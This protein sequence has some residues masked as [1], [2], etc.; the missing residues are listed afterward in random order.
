MPAKYDRIPI[1]I[2]ILLWV[3]YLVISLTTPTT[4]NQAFQLS[5]LQRYIL[6]FTISVPL[7]AIWLSGIISGHQLHNYAEHLE[8]QD[9][10][11]TF[12]RL[13]RGIYFLVLGS[14]LTTILGSVRSR[15][16]SDFSVQMTL[17]VINNY[18]YVFMPL[19][20]LSLILQSAI[21][22]AKSNRAS[23]LTFFR[24]AAAALIPILATVG[25]VWL[26]STNPS[27]QIST[28]A[29][30]SPSY[31]LPDYLIYSTIVIPSF[32]TWLIGSLAISYLRL[33]RRLV[34]GYIYQS[35]ASFFT[36]GLVLIIVSSVILQLLLSV[37]STRLL[38]LG[39]TPILAVVYLFIIF[40]TI[41]YLLIWRSA[42][43][44]FVIEK[45]LEQYSAK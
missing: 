16:L 27:R 42:K 14:I 1:V 7:L 36:A 19:I 43:K 15:F 34:A 23:N 31:Y 35:S 8:D 37:G 41:G 24:V 12:T 29:G 44:L 28:L 9:L 21:E 45:V 5:A 33:Y 3:C 22:L 26:I 10:K 13:S 38:A 32:I 6:Q 4:Q 18:L 39:L 25:H 17:T 40:Q 30:V 2:T 20:G 11:V